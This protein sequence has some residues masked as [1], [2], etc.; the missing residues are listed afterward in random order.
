[1]HHFKAIDEFKLELH[2]GNDHFRSRWLI[3]FSHVTSKFD[4]WPWN[5]LILHSA[6]SIISKPWVNSNWRYWPEMLNYGKNCDFLS[7]VTLTSDGWPWKS[8]GHPFY[9]TLSFVHHFK[10]IGKYKLELQS[11]NTRFGSKSVIF[12]SSETLKFNGWLDKQ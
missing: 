6:L 2:S 5:T 11:G 4:G 1:M 12:L 3:L 9:N 8:L 7:G 10:A